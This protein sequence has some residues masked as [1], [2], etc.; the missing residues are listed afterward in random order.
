MRISGGTARGIP[1]DVPK[2]DAVRPATDG[3]RQAVFSSIAARVPGAWFLDLCAGSGAYGLEAV[4]RGAA[5]GIFVEK[6]Q[7]A[8][9][10][11]KKNIAAVCKSARH[12]PLTLTLSQCDLAA[13]MPAP[14]APAPELVFIDPPY[15]IISRIA[16]IFFEKTAE[17]LAA[18]KDPLIV[19][20]MPSRLNLTAPDGWIIARRLGGQGAGQPNAVFYTRKR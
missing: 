19:F 4:S 7:K 1:L 6:S 12:D 11:L 17:W 5:G 9:A 2:G 13:W 15:G 20:E 18:S 10:C 3:L 8:V 14:E 16:P